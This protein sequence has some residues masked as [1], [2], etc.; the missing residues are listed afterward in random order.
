LWDLQRPDAARDPVYGHGR[1]APD[2][3]LTGSGKFEQSTPAKN[4]ETVA[5]ATTVVSDGGTVL[6]ITTKG[7]DKQRKHFTNVGVYDKR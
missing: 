1:K 6:T 5:T 7:T 4:G 3:F 2:L